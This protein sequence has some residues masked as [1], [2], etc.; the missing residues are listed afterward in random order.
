MAL[1]DS[2]GLLSD[3]GRYPPHVPVAV[4]Y[5]CGTLLVW[6]VLRRGDGCGARLDRLPETLIHIGHIDVNGGRGA[7]W[8]RWV[9]SFQNDHAIA[10]TS[11]DVKAVR[12]GMSLQLLC[13]ESFFEKV[14]SIQSAINVWS[15]RPEPV[16]HMLDCHGTTPSR[17][18]LFYL[19]RRIGTATQNTDAG[20]TCKRRR[21]RTTAVGVRAQRDSI[22]V[23][24][25]KTKG[26]RL[27]VHHESQIR[28]NEL[29]SCAHPME[30]IGY[31]GWEEITMKEALANPPEVA[32]VRYRK[33]VFA[34]VI[35]ATIVT[36]GGLFPIILWLLRWL[37]PPAWE[38][39]LASL[40]IGTAFGALL[41]FILRRSAARLEREAPGAS[42]MVARLERDSVERKRL[43][44]SIFYA[45]VLVL[46]CSITIA[47]HH[48]RD[49]HHWTLAMLQL[50]LFASLPLTEM[51][52]S[53]FGPR[54][55]R[56]ILNDEFTMA[57]RGRACTIGYVASFAGAAGLSIVAVFSPRNV[58]DGLPVLITVAAIV[59][60]LVFAI[61]E[62]RAQPNE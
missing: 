39:M 59:P 4:S 35:V 10:N 19:T 8:R 54:R 9:A 13:A 33:R 2:Y 62:R 50:V 1:F 36:S 32:A 6:F 12:T 42:V 14:D 25:I 3:V 29:P 46:F 58:L 45:V 49:R 55:Q 41:V 5:A 26:R 30:P 20:A 15:Y 27:I 21:S 22:N 31:V 34:G 17:G 51:N 16:P 60:M 28:E 47:L 37:R 56:R 44:L 18:P 40:C 43:G 57:L 53:R 24:S 38:L 48:L 61:T 7:A 11:L 52:G 23:L